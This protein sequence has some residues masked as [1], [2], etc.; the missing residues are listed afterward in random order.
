MLCWKENDVYV[1][2]GFY[3]NTHL[4]F[5]LTLV[6]FS[7]FGEA[8][9]KVILGLKD[10]NTTIRTDEVEAYQEAISEA[11]LLGNEVEEEAKIKYSYRAFKAMRPCGMQ[12]YHEKK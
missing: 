6:K 7:R 1:L 3:P 5:K 2:R 9:A 4:P 8:R 10:H 11:I 12:L